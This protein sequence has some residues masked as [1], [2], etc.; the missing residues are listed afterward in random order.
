M[1]N[2]EDHNLLLISESPFRIAQFVITGPEPWLCRIR[3]MLRQ[4]SQFELPSLFFHNLKKFFLR[5]DF[6]SCSCL[7]RFAAEHQ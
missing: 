7:I 4:P 6:I 5:L 2:L 3:L 1:C